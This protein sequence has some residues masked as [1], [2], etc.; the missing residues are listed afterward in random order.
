MTRKN[1][2]M[3]VVVF[4]LTVSQA[5]FLT[6]VSSQ[7]R[8][9]DLRTPLTSIG[10][11]DDFDV[12]RD[13]DDPRGGGGYDAEGY[14]QNVVV[15][16]VSICT[17]KLLAVFIDWTQEYSL[18][19]TSS[20]RTAASLL[21]SAS[22]GPGTPGLLQLHYRF[23]A[24]TRRSRATLFFYSP[25]GSRHEPTAIQALLNRYKVAALQDS[26]RAAIACD[27]NPTSKQTHP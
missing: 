23:R 12:P 25:D 16:K 17:D 5:C 3:S 2:S 14:F 10:V 15:D 22:M 6:S 27:S 7:E 20:S 1:V 19:I 21:A 26:M 18:T 9:G 8:S 11:V 13:P 4:C 24:D